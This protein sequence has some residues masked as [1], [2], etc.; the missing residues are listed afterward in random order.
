[1][2]F[3]RCEDISKD[4][5]TRR[6]LVWM[7]CRVQGSHARG[8]DAMHGV[9]IPCTGCVSH[10]GYLSHGNSKGEERGRSRHK[11]NSKTVV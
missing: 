4:R 11:N 1:M 8:G 7:E 9:G 6:H 3:N 10:T 5:N 2:V